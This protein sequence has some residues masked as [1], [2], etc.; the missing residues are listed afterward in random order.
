MA[1]CGNCATFLLRPCG[2]SMQCAVAIIAYLPTPPEGERASY[3]RCLAVLGEHPLKLVCPE[4]LDISLY[5]G[6]AAEHGRRIEAVRFPDAC[7]RSV[8]TYNRLM[9][10]PDFYHR[11]KAYE[12][13]L[14]YQ[15]DAWVF[16]D[17]LSDWCCRGYAYVG[18]PFFTDRGEMLPFAG[19]GGFSLRRVRTFLDIFDGAPAAIKWNYGFLAVQLPARNRFR[20]FVKRVL[21]V[22]CMGVC[23]VSPL[24]YCTHM[25]G[26]EDML[27]ARALSLMGRKNVA[28]PYVAAFFS[29]ERFPEVLD[30]MTA[31]KTPFGCHA[32]EKYGKEFFS[33]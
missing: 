23:R 18:A 26:N 14:V 27:Y 30:A 33:L 1:N 17:E 3:E 6:L 20:A 31:G 7:F 22:C 10:T 2:S 21:H 5:V 11:F 19:N 15:L 9:L 8:A 24:W 29:F 13:I 4:S 16:R 25:S 12:Y 28:P 32:Y